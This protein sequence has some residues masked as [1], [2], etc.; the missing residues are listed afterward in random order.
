MLH[1]AYSCLHY[2][3]LAMA[4]DLPDT[5][6]PPVDVVIEVFLGFILSLVGQLLCGPFHEVRVS[7]GSLLGAIQKSRDGI[8]APAYRTRDFDLFT[9][10]AKALSM[11]KRT[12]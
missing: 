1:S 10:R 7:N 5:S 2:R 4:A 3:S 8:I 11:A 12:N 6:S 9:T